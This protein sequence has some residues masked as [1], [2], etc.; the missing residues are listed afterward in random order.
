MD[1]LNFDDLEFNLYE[2]LNLPYNCTLND[3]KNKFRK[4]VK[5]FHPDKISKTEEKIYYYI[6]LANHIL[7]NVEYRSAYDAWLLTNTDNHPIEQNNRRETKEEIKKY[8]PKNAGEARR[9]YEIKCQKLW[10]RHGTYQEDT[11]N[12]STRYNDKM[13]QLNNIKDIEKEEFRNM[14]DFNRVFDERKRPGGK[15]SDNIIEYNRNK[16][17]SNYNSNSNKLKYINMRD[18]NKMYHDDTIIGSYYTSLDVAFKLDQYGQINENPIDSAI[19]NYNN[20][21]NN[22]RNV[23]DSKLDMFDI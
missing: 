13:N 10:E 3:V 15:Y 20:Q 8:F 11:R 22:L 16:E 23:H 19:S 5:K 14:K 7:T 9:E 4:L 17:L 6:T 2:I 18:F 1:K 12:F 21:T